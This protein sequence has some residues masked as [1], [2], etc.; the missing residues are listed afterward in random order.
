MLQTALAPLLSLALSLQLLSASYAGNNGNAY[1][2]DAAT[3]MALNKN[4]M[5]STIQ[6]ALVIDKIYTQCLGRRSL[7]KQLTPRALE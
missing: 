4:N 7:I 2:F 6:I 3:L 5:A 1:N